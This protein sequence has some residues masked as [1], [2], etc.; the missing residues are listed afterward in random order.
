MSDIE[1]VLQDIQDNKTSVYGHITEL[2]EIDA[3]IEAL[4][5]N[6]SLK[7]MGISFGRIDTKAIVDLTNTIKAHPT[8]NAMALRFCMLNQGMEGELY[9]LAKLH[10]SSRYVRIENRDSHYPYQDTLVKRKLEDATF[11]FEFYGYQKPLI[12]IYYKATL[13]TPDNKERN[14]ALLA[15]A[16][17]IKLEANRRHYPKTLIDVFCENNNVSKELIQNILAQLP[18]HTNLITKSDIK[19]MGEEWK[20][21]HRSANKQKSDSQQNGTIHPN[22]SRAIDKVCEELDTRI[23]QKQAVEIIV[24]AFTGFDPE[25][26]QIIQEAFDQKRISFS[27]HWYANHCGIIGENAFEPE[28]IKILPTELKGKPYISIPLETENSDVSLRKLLVL[29]HECGHL[30]AAERCCAAGAS[31]YINKSEILHEMDAILGEKIVYKYIT[32]KGE[33]LPLQEFIFKNG[34]KNIAEIQLVDCVNATLLMENLMAAKY[35][36]DDS[37]GRKLSIKEL[38]QITEPIFPTNHNAWGD[39]VLLL[40]DDHYCMSYVISQAVVETLRKKGE[41]GDLNVAM[42]VAEIQR[43]GNNTDFN[44]AM[45]DMGIDPSAPSFIGIV[46]DQLEGQKENTAIALSKVRSQTQIAR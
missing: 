42:K 37:S 17:N 11:Q 7:E 4:A 38:K 40:T 15:E 27:P 10:N 24:K 21:L 41:A 43:K 1:Q 30:V 19:I 22:M 20:Y 14:E 25:M 44:R 3:F 28:N 29:A 12:E 33:L 31:K 45:S 36:E 35:P 32:E 13:E 46:I 6:T 16:I 9:G 8:L 26:G 5:K 2:T 23:T 34:H 18:K 39:F